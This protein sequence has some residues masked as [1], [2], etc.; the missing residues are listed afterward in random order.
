MVLHDKYYESPVHAYTSTY[1]NLND[2]ANTSVNCALLADTYTPDLDAHQMWADVSA[3]EIDAS[4]NDGY[5]AGG[6]ALTTMSLTRASGSQDSVFDA[7]NVTW[8]NSTIT[9]RYAVLYEAG[10][11]ALISLVDFEQLEDSENGDFS[12]EWDAAGIFT[13]SVA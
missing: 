11:G 9:A 2:S 4:T 8:S 12:I 7:D 5:S 13:V 3:D 6:Q 10:S 1:N